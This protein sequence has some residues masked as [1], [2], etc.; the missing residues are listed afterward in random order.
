MK[1]ELIPL[2]FIILLV[3]AIFTGFIFYNIFYGTGY[4]VQLF[5]ITTIDVIR[6]LIEDLKNYL[7]LSLTY[8][9]HQSLREHACKGGIIEVEEGKV[10]VAPWI[11]NKPFP[12]PAEFSKNCLEN[13]TKYYLNIYLGEF[14][15]SLPIKL[16][17]TNFTTCIYNIEDVVSGKYDEGNF[18]VN[19][20][21]AKITI[22]GEN[23]YEYEEIG[24]NDFISKNRYW[25]LFRIFTEWAE[26]NVYA[27]CICSKI[28]CACNSN[29]GEEFC[30]SSCL[31]QVEDCARKALE[32][33]QRRFDE[34]VKCEKLRICCSQGKGPSCLSPSPCLAWENRLCS[35]SCEHKC[36]EP[37]PPEKICPPQTS[38]L[39]ASSQNIAS[40]YI[41]DI[42]KFSD[43]SNSNLNCKC[44]YW[45]EARI[46]SAHEFRCTDYKYYIPSSKGPLPLTFAVSAYAYWRDQ[47]ACITENTCNCPKDATSCNECTPINCCTG[48]YPV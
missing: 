10:I 33:L 25:Y 14:N 38:S 21:K 26:D 47:D 44:R 7:K 22:S 13:Y 36:Y 32:D 19:C 11:C 41:S 42:V 39:Y 45:Y 31:S 9:S 40:N 4:Q 37:Y 3:A 12:V 46:A 5:Y 48:C 6:N 18:W 17:K 27:S 28:G 8:S 23:I 2:V 43:D 35:K 29:S 1:G 15:T 24:I 20:S 16:L 34:Y 30:S